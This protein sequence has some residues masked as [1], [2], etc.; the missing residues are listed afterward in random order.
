MTDDLP[1][2]ANP[3]FGELVISRFNEWKYMARWT[4]LSVDR[5]S[6]IEE[7]VADNFR[8]PFS[9]VL[10]PWLVRWPTEEGVEKPEWSTFLVKTMNINDLIHLKCMFNDVA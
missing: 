3:Y 1:W 6:T 8:D 10:H 4:G 7:W 9:V 2:K 5:R